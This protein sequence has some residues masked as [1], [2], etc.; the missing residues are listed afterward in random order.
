MSKYRFKTACLETACLACA[1]AALCGCLASAPKPPV[2]W[3]VAYPGRGEAGADAAKPADGA[4]LRVARL[5]VR[6]PFD[7]QRLAVLRADGS[8]A[9]DPR[10]SFAAPPA[11]LL[12]GAALDAANASP[13][14]A[15]AIDRLSSASTAYSIEISVARFALDCKTENSRKASV[16]LTVSLLDA[17]NVVATAAAEAE[18]D[19]AGGDYTAAFS[20]A[21]GAAIDRALGELRIPPG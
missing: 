7:G 11:A 12:R 10:N 20:K 6:A 8:I 18:A 5:D 16:A 4:V 21:F 13:L 3:T 17:R 15:A 19:A 1:A 14:A 9:F 2:M